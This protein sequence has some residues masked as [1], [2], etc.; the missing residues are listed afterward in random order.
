ML[1]R[2]PRGESTD[3]G[4]A[5][6]RRLI[7]VGADREAE[8]LENPQRRGVV[9]GRIGA[10][11]DCATRSGNLHEL[12]HG[13]QTEASAARPSREP[14][15]SLHDA[16]RLCPLETNGSHY[17]AVRQYRPGGLTQ[18]TIHAGATIAVEGSKPTDPPATTISHV[19]RRSHVLGAASVSA[20]S[21][22]RASICS[23]TS[24]SVR[25]E[26]SPIT[27]VSS[28]ERDASRGPDHARSAR[29][30]AV[31][32]SLRALM[33]ATAALS[34]RRLSEKDSESPVESHKRNDQRDSKATPSRDQQ[35]PV[36]PRV[37]EPFASCRVPYDPSGCNPQ[38]ETTTGACDPI[39]SR[40]RTVSPEQQSK[41]LAQARLLP[42]SPPNPRLFTRVR[43]TLVTGR[44][45][46]ERQDP[47]GQDLGG[48]RAGRQPGS[49]PSI[50]GES[51]R[52][53]AVMR[54]RGALSRRW[55]TSSSDRA[56]ATDRRLNGA[57]GRAR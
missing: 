15:A 26:C 55:R 17:A 50:E 27:A 38:T 35:T 14:D 47:S 56:I 40:S 45:E 20:S 3:S 24:A 30:W 41:S 46:T 23:S 6:L 28:C 5:L 25:P 8:T 13:A 43:L 21:T 22:S 32:R 1:G 53:T 12:D 39:A 9:H 51:L 18:R 42:W 7:P 29:R 10:H 48:T 2:S 49:R 36:S 44:G 34:A 37:F 33:A 54:S 16:R 57:A 52:D 19:E 11:T 31:R 4:V